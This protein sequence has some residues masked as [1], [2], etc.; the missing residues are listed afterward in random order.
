[1]T[2]TLRLVALSCTTAAL[3][4]AVGYKAMGEA[5]VDANGTLQEPFALIP[6]GWLSVAGAVVSGTAAVISG[7]RARR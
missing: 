6:L 1:M 4:C 3:L 5:R 7:K 2:K